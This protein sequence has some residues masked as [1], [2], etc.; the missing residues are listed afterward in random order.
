MTRKALGAIALVTAMSVTGMAMGDEVSDKR[1]AVSSACVGSNAN[2]T[3][4]Q[5]AVLAFV[6]ALKAK[7]PND[8]KAV[9][10]ALGNLVYELLGSVTL[11]SLPAAA[12]EVLA[13]GIAQAAA[14]VT[15]TT[16]KNNISSVA[17]A[18]E[19]GTPIPTIEVVR[20]NSASQSSV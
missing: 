9:D 14:A 3:S 13:A 5:S 1:G 4:C 20:Q 6:A 8:T 10:G 18:V 15:D 11:G 17:T 7:Y 16:Q 2:K 19:S 12:R